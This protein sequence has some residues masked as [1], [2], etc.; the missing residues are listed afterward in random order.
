MFDLPAPNRPRS[1]SPPRAPTKRRATTPAS[2]TLID[3][4]AHRAARRRRW[5]PTC[6]GSCPRVAVS[7]SGPAGSLTQVRIRGAE[8]NHTLLFVEGIRANDPAAGN[9]PRFELLNADLASRIEVV[10]GPQSA[11]W[12][13]EA[14]GGVVA[15]N[16]AAPGSG[17]TQAFAEGGSL[18]TLARRGPDQRSASADRGLSLGVAGAAQRRHRQLFGE[19]RQGRLSQPRGC[20]LPAAIACDPIVCSA[21]PALRSAARANS[22]ALIPSPS[23]TPIRST[24]RATGWRR[25]ACLPT[26]G[27]REQRLCR[28]FREPARLVQPQRA[29]WRSPVNT[30]R[31]PPHRS[32]LEGGHRFGQHRCRARSK[33]KRE[34]F[35]A[36]DTAFGGFT[37]QDRI[38]QPSLA[39]GSNGARATS[40]PSSRPRRPAATSSRAFK[41][42]TTLRGS[43]LSDTGCAASRSR[44][45]MAKALPSRP[46]STCTASSPALRRQPALQAGIEP[47]RRTLA[48]LSGADRLGGRPDLLPPAA[49][50]RDRRRLR[51]PT[52][53]DAPP[54][55]TA[56]ASRQ[57]IEARRLII[58]LPTRLRLTATYAWLDASEPDR[59][60]RRS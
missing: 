11:L 9:E 17:G 10:R 48:A 31:Q 4:A 42:A 44:R 16:G 27:D 32:R 50:G 1:S 18:D 59:R 39:D 22:T 46:F 36:R 34:T 47:R 33:A 53:L 12:G 60:R 52:S 40:A 21:R 2:V 30:P 13:S 54:T 8:A 28:R 24:K 14:I 55:P 19:R 15:V 29:R 51:F 3:G 38:A 37:N 45:T 25:D 57:G 56:R 35:D 20:A 23:S 58:S 43:A 6:C 7:V 49:E 26:C 41:D 5:S